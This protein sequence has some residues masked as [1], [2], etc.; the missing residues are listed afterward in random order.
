MASSALV[1][2]R[3]PW[4]DTEEGYQGRREGTTQGGVNKKGM[5]DGQKVKE[6]ESRKEGRKGR[7]K[8]KRGNVGRKG[9]KE[10]KE[11]EH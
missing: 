6:W 4:T 8:V 9:R 7:E 10:V 5:K 11:G 3:I 2:G 1:P